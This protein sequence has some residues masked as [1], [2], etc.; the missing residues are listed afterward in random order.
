MTVQWDL[1]IGVGNAFCADD[2]VGPWIAERLK[3]AGLSAEV[4]SGEGASLMERWR[5]QGNVLVI[6]ATRTGLAAGTVHRL[7]AL[8]ETIPGGFF[9]YSSHQFGLAEAIEISRV[10]EHLPKSLQI[11]GIEGGNFQQGD[12]LS[13]AVEKAASDIV[14]DLLHNTL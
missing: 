9:S 7:D 6:D 12:S 11:I 10:L 1:I 3:A 5:D 14:K 13:P 4:M 2:G 8:K